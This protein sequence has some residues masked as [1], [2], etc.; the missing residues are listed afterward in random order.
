MPPGFPVRG[1]KRNKGQTNTLW[2]ESLLGSYK[3][4]AGYCI[5]KEYIRDPKKTDVAKRPKAFGHVGILVTG[6]PDTGGLP[7]IQSPDA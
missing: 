7:F 2:N 6:P 3:M 4:Q 1:M 5:Q